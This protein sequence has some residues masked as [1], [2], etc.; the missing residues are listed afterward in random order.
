LL[1]EKRKGLKKQSKLKVKQKVKAY[2]LA[3]SLLSITR[4]GKGKERK[5]DSVE[6]RK[7]FSGKFWGLSA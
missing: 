5:M 6:A 3:I 1:D 7:C 2:D 4:K